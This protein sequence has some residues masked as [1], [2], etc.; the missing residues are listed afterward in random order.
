MEGSDTAPAPLAV[1]VTKAWPLRKPSYQPSAMGWSRTHLR[2]HT[3]SGTHKCYSLRTAKWTVNDMFITG[4]CEKGNPGKAIDQ[5]EEQ[6]LMNRD[7]P[8][9]LALLMESIFL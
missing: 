3:K 1:V 2:R 6:Y 5:P 7:H 8:E 9:L 4:G